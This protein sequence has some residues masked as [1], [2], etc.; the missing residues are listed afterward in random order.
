MN[1]YTKITIPFL[2]LLLSVTS[3]T[4]QME[5]GDYKAYKTNKGVREDIPINIHV[6]KFSRDFCWFTDAETKEPL[7]GQYHIIENTMKYNA[8]NL[9][10]GFTDGDYE[11]YFKDRLNYKCTYE[12]GRKHGKS[13]SYYDNGKIKSE[14]TYKK[15][16]YTQSIILHSVS[17]H[18]NGKLAEEP[19]YDE[20]GKRH[21][22]ITQYDDNGNI[23]K[24]QEYEHGELIGQ[25]WEKD[26]N[27]NTIIK[28]Y[29]DGFV[30]MESRFYPNGN[31][32]SKE[33]YEEKRERI[34]TGQWIKGKENG[35]LESEIQYLKDKK[36]GEEKIYYAGNKLKSITE[37]TQGKRNGKEIVYEEDPH[38]I[39][40]EGTFKEGERHGTFK[41]YHNGILWKETIYNEDKVISEKQYE[42]GKLQLLNLLDESGTLVNVEK[43]NNQ[44]TKTYRNP[45]Y[46]KHPSVKIE[47]DASGIIDVSYE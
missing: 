19:Q 12:A 23:N 29:G 31:I 38:V 1:M 33:Q 8:V 2:L 11:Y 46:K 6:E 44:G 30:I 21:G 37:Y 7:T 22:K 36:N 25:S 17:Y 9:N 27:G 3:A 24:K 28:E 4:G 42:N 5:E 18:E 14:Y 34:R 10:K 20:N 26:N 40:H 43:Y 13:I 16:E 15:Q 39:K 32:K 47:E 35:D 45:N 41:T